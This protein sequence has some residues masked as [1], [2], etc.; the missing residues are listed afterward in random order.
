MSR[1]HSILVTALLCAAASACAA[2]TSRAPVRATYSTVM[3]KGAAQV[4]NYDGDALPTYALADAGGYV[5]VQC[6][7]GQV[8]QIVDRSQDLYSASMKRTSLGGQQLEGICDRVK[9][10]RV[11]HFH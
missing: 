3:P 10:S 8:Y 2:N 11:D 9:G 1:T 7:N 5:E 4:R 6:H